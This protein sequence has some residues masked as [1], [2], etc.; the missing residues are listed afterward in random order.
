MPEA[1]N[2]LIP[3]RS[4]WL[5][6]RH[7]H[8]D[9][10]LKKEIHSYNTIWTPFSAVA[11]FVCFAGIRGTKGWQRQKTIIVESAYYRFPH[12]C[13]YASTIVKSISLWLSRTIL[14]RRSTK[15]SQS[16]FTYDLWHELLNPFL[17]HIIVHM[18][19][20]KDNSSNWLILSQFVFKE[21]MF[22]KQNN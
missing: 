20:L 9:N 15:D 16:T 22:W 1:Q 14:I 17:L 3:P 21:C 18:I 10:I 7:L 5:I 4:L 13:Y 6:R 11:S 12:V 8:I 19:I 2:F